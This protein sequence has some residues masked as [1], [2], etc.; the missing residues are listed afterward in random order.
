MKNSKPTLEVVTEMAFSQN[1]SYVQERRVKLVFI[2]LSEVCNK[3]YIESITTEDIVI[4][5]RHWRQGGSTAESLRKRIGYIR[6][7]LKFA[8]SKRYIRISPGDFFRTPNM[9]RPEPV[10]LSLEEVNLLKGKKMILS[11]YEKARDL[12]LFQTFTGLAYVDLMG[13]KKDWIVMV[14]GKRFIIAD[15]AKNGSD[16]IIPLLPEALAVAAKYNYRLPRYSN[17]YYNRLLK[18]VGRCCK[19]ETKLTSHVF[20]RTFGQMMLDMGISMEAVSKMLGHKTVAVT[21]RHYVRVGIRRMVKDV[22]HLAA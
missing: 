7:V 2:Q 4:I 18:I 13:F 12:A 5:Y 16:F 3:E 19:I 8:V 1:M 20:R 10:S 14:D 21:E 17:A 15:R 11:E 9:P 22:L 6:R